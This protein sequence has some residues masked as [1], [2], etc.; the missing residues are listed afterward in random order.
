MQSELQRCGATKTD[1]FQSRGSAPNGS[2][3]YLVQ[4]RRQSAE[5]NDS[6]GMHISRSSKAG[7]VRNMTGYYLSG[8]RQSVGIDKSQANRP[9]V[10]EHRPIHFGGYLLQSS[11]F[12]PFT[13]RKTL[14]CVTSTTSA[15][16][17][18]AAIIKS[19]LPIGSPSFSRL[20]RMRA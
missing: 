19:R 14:S 12:S 2:V 5:L 18:C 17:A 10:P 8:S 3:R 20:A 13:R 4:P 9:W 6:L 1:L 16:T 11:T 7:K 15:A